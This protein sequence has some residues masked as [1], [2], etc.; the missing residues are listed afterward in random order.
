MPTLDRFEELRIAYDEAF[1]R[2]RRE[3]TILKSVDGHG[4]ENLQYR[5]EAAE[6]AYRRTRDALA[7]FLIDQQ[8]SVEERR[9]SVSYGCR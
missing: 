1:E 4:F 8:S 3:V 5:V 9:S 2:L 6:A 7:Q